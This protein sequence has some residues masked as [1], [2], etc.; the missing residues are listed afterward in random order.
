MVT[1]FQCNRF[2]SK[3]EVFSF[4]YLKISLWG[5]VHNFARLPRLYRGVKDPLSLP[6]P[7]S[8]T[9]PTSQRAGCR[10]RRTIRS[11]E[12]FGGANPFVQTNC[13]RK[14]SPV[15]AA[16]AGLCWLELGVGS[17]LDPPHPS[18]SPSPQKPLPHPCFPGKAHERPRFPQS[19]SA[20]HQPNVSPLWGPEEP[21]EVL[22]HWWHA[23]PSWPAQGSLDHRQ[24]GV[25]AGGT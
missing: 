10:A 8:Y 3:S 21:A 18:T 22:P 15:H 1:A 4:T 19:T 2:P 24:S 17:F 7:A 11:Y 13:I 12:H 16:K 9:Q 6:R 5:G 14:P 20:N 25:G 23:L